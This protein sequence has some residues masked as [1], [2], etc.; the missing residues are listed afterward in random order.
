MQEY[1]PDSDKIQELMEEFI[2]NKTPAFEYYLLADL[3]N[4]GM[5]F[6]VFTTN[7]DNFIHEAMSFLGTRARVC[8]YDD[9]ASSISYI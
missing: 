5:L 3:I 7:F 6:N 8:I 1:S 4:Q 2:E 9:K